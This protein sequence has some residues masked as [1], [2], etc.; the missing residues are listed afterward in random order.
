MKNLLLKLRMWLFSDIIAELRGIRAE[1]A[2]LRMDRLYPSEER[3]AGAEKPFGPISPI[4]QGTR[5][6]W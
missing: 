3:E 1:L 6:F 5:N 4:G 2:M